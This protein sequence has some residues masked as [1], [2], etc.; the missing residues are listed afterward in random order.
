[1]EPAGSGAT[2]TIAASAVRIGRAE[3]ARVARG[4]GALVTEGVNARLVAVRS[5]AWLDI[6]CGLMCGTRDNRLLRMQ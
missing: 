2:W 5:I 1:M 4:G 3:S 6:S